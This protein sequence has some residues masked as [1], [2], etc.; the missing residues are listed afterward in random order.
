MSDEKY[1]HRMI[2]C[3]LHIDLPFI[4]CECFVMTDQN[5]EEYSTEPF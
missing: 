4:E 3:D 1:K 2:A 5:H